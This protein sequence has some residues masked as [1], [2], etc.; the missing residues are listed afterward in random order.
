MKDLKKVQEFFSKSLEEID[1]SEYAM[2][3]RADKDKRANLKPNPTRGIDYDEALNL[4]GIKSEI[5]DRIKQLYIDMEQEAEPEGGEV[6]DRYGSELDKLEDRLYKVQKQLR[7]YDMNEDQS[8]SSTFGG[9]SKK[10]DGEKI[11]MEIVKS[12]YDIIPTDIWN[13]ILV[14]KDG[15]R[16]GMIN[17]DESYY[18][19]DG[20]M[21]KWAGTPDFIDHIESKNINENDSYARVSMPRFVKDKNNPNFLN[22][23]IDYDI[24]PGGAS[25]A[26]GKETMTGQIR[27]LSAAKA[28]RLADD[29][30]RDLEAEYNLE[31]IEVTDLKNGKVRIFAVSDDFIDMNPNMLGEIKESLNP[32]VSNAVNRFIKAMAKRYDYSEQDA[33]FAIMAA[34]KQRD[35]DGEEK[36]SKFKKAGEA[37]GFD[38]RGLKEYTRQDLGMSSSISKRRAKAELKNPGNDGSKVYGLDKD[39]K[40]VRIKSINDVDKFTKFEIDADINENKVADKDIEKEIKLL[41]KE[42]PKGYAAEI[43][44]LKVRLAAINLSKKEVNE[45]TSAET[46]SEMFDALKTLSRAFEKKANTAKVSPKDKE[47]DEGIIT[48]GATIVGAPGLMTAL[49]KGANYLGKAFGKDKNAIG[50]FL[51]KKGHQLEEFYIESIGGWLQTAFPNRYKGQDVT[52]AESDLHKTA[53]KA[54][55]AMLSV[56]A[57]GA[58]YE[59]GAAANVVKAG[60]EGGMAVLK[61][62]EVVDIVRKLV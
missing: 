22:V 33:V 61:T 29:V 55:A 44:K 12:G 34:L 41:Q 59:A 23:Y 4:R 31:D 14:G 46:S 53:Q 32:E 49:G 51:K 20:K 28:M 35:F 15:K 17:T 27:R 38:M 10:L 2:R 19:I 1:N 48:L 3:L 8:Y 25:I 7:D 57:I 18:N 40:R 54:Y 50:E 24:G 45:N 16:V 52:N 58:G 9:S 11:E 47:L 42:N 39:G 36:K 21:Y 6:A 13:R 30:A 26:L 56:A 43:K 60:V 5:E 62:S 37:S